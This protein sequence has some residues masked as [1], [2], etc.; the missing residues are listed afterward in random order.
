MDKPEAQKA[1]YNRIQKFDENLEDF[2]NE[3]IQKGEDAGLSEEM[4]IKSIIMNMR[5]K[6]RCT[7]AYSCVRKCLSRNLLKL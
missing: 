7:L 2:C 6:K 5:Q 1:F 3:M 4:I